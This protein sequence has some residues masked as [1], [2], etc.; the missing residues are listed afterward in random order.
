[1]RILVVEDDTILANGIT[2]GLVQEGYAADWVEEA[3]SAELALDAQNYDLIL[4]DIGLPGKSGL[5]LL[6][7]LRGKKSTLP[8]IILTAYDATEDKI[9]G[10]DAGADDYL[11]KPFD[12]G[13]LF[14][15]VRA[16]RRRSEG[17]ATPVIEVKDITLDPAAHKV[18]KNGEKIDLGPREFAILRSLMERAGRVLTKEQLENSLYGWNMEI[19]SNTVE[20]HIHGLRK[21]LGRDLIKTIRGV[22][23]IIET[24][25]A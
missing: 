16:L 21:K 1:M 15:R 5:N 2:E 13:E 10:L 9:R 4:L 17:S 11:I 3:E 8:V 19:E 14:A 12:L 18:T 6:K 22:G 25:S 20:V 24:D 23:Y 7:D